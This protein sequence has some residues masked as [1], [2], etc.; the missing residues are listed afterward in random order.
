MKYITFNYSF[1]KIL[2]RQYKKT[3]ECFSLNTYLC[4]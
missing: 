4:Y 1:D 3:K 2:P